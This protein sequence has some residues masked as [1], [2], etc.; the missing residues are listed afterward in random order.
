MKIKL[1][2]FIIIISIIF[3][4]QLL[5]SL[6][7]IN[8]FLFSSPLEILKCLIDLL[9]ANKLFINTFVTLF[10]VII[11]FI[12]S[13]SLSFIF[14]SI[15]I[16]NSTIEKVIDPFLTV[17]NALPKV[18]LA[19]L[20]ILIFGASIKSIII[21]S[22]LIGV[23]VT[24]IN[25]YNSFKNTNKDY[26]LL[27]KSFNGTKY[28]IYKYA[29]LPSNIENIIDAFSI[30]MSMTFIGGVTG[31]L[32]VSKNGLGYLIN[33]GTSVFNITLIITSIIILM[34]LSFMLYE[35]III[36]KKKIVLK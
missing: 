22:V 19:P 1:I 2:R 31:E 13:S 18:A 26:I 14:A 17:L 16:N 32:L 20:I 25:I 15:L 33:Y 30:N 10:E 8:V 34:I 4:W 29:Y 6:N 21:M 9:K 24:T 5:A 3:I 12:I 7:I 35:I 11:S 28:D 23:F 36:I 27:I